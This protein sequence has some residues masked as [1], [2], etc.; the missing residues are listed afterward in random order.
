MNI[1]VG[2]LSYSVTADELRNAFA[3]HGEVSEV[4]LISD[5]FTGRSKG[6]A[7]VVMPNN[8]EAEAAVKA[9][10]GTDLKG[11]TITVNEARPREERPPRPR[12]Y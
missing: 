8:S 12:R 4:N 6:F 10:N 3:E 1:Y 9:L 7:F 2:N 5:K 11:R